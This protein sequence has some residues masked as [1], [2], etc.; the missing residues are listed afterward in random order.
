MEQT[1]TP[2]SAVRVRIEPGVTAHKAC[3]HARHIGCCPECQRAQL[4]RW[5]VQLAQ[6]T[7]AGRRH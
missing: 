3:G 1:L 6:A 7:R 2:R 4:A 5:D